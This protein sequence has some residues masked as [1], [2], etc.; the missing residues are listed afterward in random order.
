MK[1]FFKNLA[2]SLIGVVILL[3]VFYF[4]WSDVNKNNNISNTKGVTSFTDIKSGLES[5]IS[6]LEKSNIKP[7]EKIKL[8]NLKKVNIRDAAKK[9]LDYINLSYVKSIE[10]KGEMLVWEYQPDKVIK[11]QKEYNFYNI[12]DDRSKIIIEDNIKANIYLWET[13][14]KKLS[15]KDKDNILTAIDY[16]NLPLEKYKGELEV[17]T[18]YTCK[19]KK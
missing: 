4:T 8:I 7:K 10:L 16:Y 3:T 11:L 12:S 6:V 18:K 9:D 15:V 17:M 5:E 1:K 14:K 19:T 13:S 2:L